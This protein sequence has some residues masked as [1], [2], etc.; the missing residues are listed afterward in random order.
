MIYYHLIIL[1]YIDI[2][3]PE[4]IDTTDVPN[5]SNYL[6]L[7]LEMNDHGILQSGTQER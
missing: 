6:N 3:Y 4:I 1:N 7:R 5:F 2:I